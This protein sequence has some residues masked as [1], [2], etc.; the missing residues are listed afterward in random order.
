MNKIMLKEIK[1]YRNGIWPYEQPYITIAE[2]AIS[3]LWNEW[4][5]E[6]ERD[7]STD[8]SGSCKFAAL[9][10]LQLFGGR[11]SGNFN[12]CFVLLNKQIIDLNREQSDV[13]EL[14]SRAY[15]HTPRE[16]YCKEYRE[17]L[18]SCLPRVE[19]W[20]IWCLQQASLLAC[21]V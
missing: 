15:L 16:I 14:G 21:K 8:R 13:I 2:T 17:S 9:L 6:R 18:E 4:L 10:S 1:S 12:H 20:F 5:A 7:P 19:R 3:H 11:L